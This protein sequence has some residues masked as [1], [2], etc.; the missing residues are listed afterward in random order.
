MNSSRSIIS[1]II[2]IITIIIYIY[3][4]NHIIIIMYHMFVG[5]PGEPRAD[6]VR[7]ALRDDLTGW[8]GGLA[9]G[10]GCQ[11][12]ILL[13]KTVFYVKRDFWI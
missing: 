3:I 5:V 4:Y 8:I 10:G 9:E 12:K 13:S 11:Y 1:S 6:A 2:I 7:E